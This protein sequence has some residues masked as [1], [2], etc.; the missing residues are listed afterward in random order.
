MVVL[1]EAGS[2]VVTLAGEAQV[3]GKGFAIAVRVLVRLAVAKRFALDVPAP[4][5]DVAVGIDDDAC[6]IEVIGFDI[7]Q[8]L[9]VVAQ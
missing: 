8:F 1:V 7:G 3:E 2:A 5:L 6:C 9:I 4:N